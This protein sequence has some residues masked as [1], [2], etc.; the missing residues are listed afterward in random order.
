MPTARRMS[1]ARPASR[2]FHPLT[3]TSPAS[4]S[5][6]ALRCLAS[7]DLPDPLW[8]RIDHVFSLA[9]LQI[10]PAQRLHGLLVALLVGVMEILDADDGH[11]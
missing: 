10:H 2:V 5:S 8:P 3:H 6:S 7:V 1:S 4:G 9:H 11:G